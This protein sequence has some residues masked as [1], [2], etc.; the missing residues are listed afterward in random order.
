MVDIQ[1]VDKRE[2]PSKSQ[3]FSPLL[4]ELLAAKVC[5]SPL[6]CFSLCA[7]PRTKEFAGKIHRCNLRL[8]HFRL[9]RAEN[10]VFSA[11]NSP[12]TLFSTHYQ[13]F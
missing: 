9:I 8:K 6:Y 4:Y 2:S 13:P 11:L 1:F 12:L 7:M 5:S 10:V 3:R